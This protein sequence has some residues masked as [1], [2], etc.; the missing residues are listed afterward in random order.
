MVHILFFTLLLL[1][2]FECWFVFNVWSKF[3]HTNISFWD[4]I[5]Y[6]DTTALLAPSHLLFPLPTTTLYPLLQGNADILAALVTPR[7]VTARPLF[8]W[9]DV[10]QS[11]LAAVVP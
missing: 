6:V 3:E 9:G 11:T 1:L 5:H 2:L 4:L 10:G 7:L 8:L